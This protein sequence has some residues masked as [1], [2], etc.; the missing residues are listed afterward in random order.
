MGSSKSP[1]NSSDS[2]CANAFRAM[3]VSHVRTQLKASSLGSLLTLEGLVDVDGLLGT[4]LEVRD[5]A[6]GL[7]EGHGSLVGDLCRDGQWSR[8]VISRSIPH[9]PLACYPPHRSCCRERPEA[10]S[11]LALLESITP[12]HSLRMGSLWGLLEKPG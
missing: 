11:T 1:L 8:P 4:C 2:S 7:T 10:L 6:L 12:R 5:I 9:V 3:T